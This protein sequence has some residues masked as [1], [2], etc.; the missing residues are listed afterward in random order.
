MTELTALLRNTGS[1]KQQLVIHLNDALR[2]YRPNPCSSCHT[3][4]LARQERQ[5]SLSNENNTNN[6]GSILLL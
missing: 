1:K 6:K 3:T 2:Q 4:V 5:G